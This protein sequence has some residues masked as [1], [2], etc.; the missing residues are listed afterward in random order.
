MANRLGLRGDPGETPI[1]HLVSCTLDPWLTDTERGDFI[2][3]LREALAEGVR[4]AIR[5]VFPEP[6]G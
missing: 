4:A 2:P 5:E 1:S 6:A 3:V